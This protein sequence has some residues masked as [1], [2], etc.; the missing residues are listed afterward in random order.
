MQPTPSGQRAPL[1]LAK[2][3]R[4][5]HIDSMTAHSV[6]WPHAIAPLGD[7]ALTVTCERTAANEAPD[8]A[9]ALATACAHAALTG[10]DAVVPAIDSVTVYYDPARVTLHRLTTQI[11]ALLSTLTV[12]HQTSPRTVTIPVC[13]AEEFGPD[14]AALAATHDVTSADA[15]DR[16][17][18]ATYSVAMVGFLP[19]FGYLDGLPARL[20]TPRR[21]Q[22]RTRVPAGSVA[23]GGDRAGVYPFESP[24]G[25]HLIGRTPRRMFDA[26]R[27][28][29]SVLQQGDTVRFTAISA[30]E[31]ARWTEAP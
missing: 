30:H 28:E 24:G 12:T 13:F 11:E 4:W 3:A 21:A 23:I 7:L 18:D 27:S 5:A 22:P 15:I 31:F 1:R 17:L 14:L 10:V 16:F 8:I 20:A 26:A 9:R 19:G 25:W 29:P 6:P 2:T